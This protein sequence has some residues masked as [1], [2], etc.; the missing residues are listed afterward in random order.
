MKVLRVPL[1]Y[2]RPIAVVIAVMDHLDDDGP[3][4]VKFTFGNFA[5]EIGRSHIVGGEN[6]R[7][8][9]EADAD[10]AGIARI[11]ALSWR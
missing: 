4:D 5:F 9:R 8:L 6:L 2:H 1:Q 7:K 10:E 11:M 3:G